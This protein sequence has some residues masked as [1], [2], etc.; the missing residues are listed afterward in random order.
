MALPTPTVLRHLFDVVNVI[1]V[2]FKL[3]RPFE[4]I[5]IYIIYIYIYRYIYIYYKLILSLIHKDI[6]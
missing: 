4:V 1:Y 2:S 5:I 6:I 3:S